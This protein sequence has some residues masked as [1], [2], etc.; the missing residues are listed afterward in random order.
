MTLRP[1]H[2]R[3]RWRHLCPTLAVL[4]ANLLSG[5]GAAHAADAGLREKGRALLAAQCARC[6]AIASSGTSPLPAAPPLRDLKRKYPPSQLA[7]ALAEGIVSGHPDM[8]EAV[9]EPDEIGAI[10]AYLESLAT[11]P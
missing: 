3:P 4:L 11:S 7:E 10:I 6:H 2:L 8:P 5:P 1:R 9:F